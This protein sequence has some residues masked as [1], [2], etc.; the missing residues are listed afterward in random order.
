MWEL[1]AAL[2]LARHLLERDEA[3][4]AA[5]LIHDL[6][7]RVDLESNTPEVHRLLVLIDAVR[8]RTSIR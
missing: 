7:K 6:S 5:S 8:N 3:D 4:G 2:D 1:R